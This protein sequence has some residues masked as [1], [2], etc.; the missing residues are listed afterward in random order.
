MGYEIMKTGVLGWW[1]WGGG[2][3]AR[4]KGKLDLISYIPTGKHLPH[5]RETSQEGSYQFLMIK[6]QKKVDKTYN[7]GNFMI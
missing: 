6:I 4:R 1:G 5:R 2:K 7:L 3:M